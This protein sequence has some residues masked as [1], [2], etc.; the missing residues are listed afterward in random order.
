MTMTFLSSSILVSTPLLQAF[1]FSYSSFI[2]LSYE[3]R[4][5]IISSIIRRFSLK[6]FYLIDAPLS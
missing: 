1:V 6:M 4:G 5:T 2:S 3:L